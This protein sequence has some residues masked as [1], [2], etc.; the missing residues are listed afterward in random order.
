MVD[1]SETLIKKGLA[2]IPKPNINEDIGKALEMTID[3]ADFI[4]EAAT[5]GSRFN[6]KRYR[7]E[8]TDLI[9]FLKNLRDTTS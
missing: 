6:K 5:W 3:L 8:I 9:G 2:K 4:N 7:N 1:Y